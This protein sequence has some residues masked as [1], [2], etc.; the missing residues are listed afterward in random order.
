MFGQDG[1]DPT[2]A[3]ASLRGLDP[4]VDVSSIKDSG[5]N[6]DNA[7]GETTEEIMYPRVGAVPARAHVPSQP[8]FTDSKSSS[9]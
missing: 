3:L 5:I 9:E 2:S 4:T 8:R 6:L 7:C 1:G